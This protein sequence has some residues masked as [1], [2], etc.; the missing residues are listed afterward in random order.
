MRHVAYTLQPKADELTSALANR[1]GYKNK[2][3]VISWDHLPFMQVFEKDKAE[4]ES[5]KIETFANLLNIGV[6]L[7]E[8]NKYLDL[9]FTTGERTNQTGAAGTDKGQ[10]QQQQTQGGN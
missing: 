5:K 8:A 2:E 7:E 3:I 1:W 9:E 6:S 10:N 4:T